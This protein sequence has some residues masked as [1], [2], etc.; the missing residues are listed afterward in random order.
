MTDKETSVLMDFLKTP[1]GMAVVMA[2][3]NDVIQAKVAER[4]ELKKK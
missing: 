3:I 1:S 4:S 2:R